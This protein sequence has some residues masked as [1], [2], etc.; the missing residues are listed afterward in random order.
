MRTYT[1][2]YDESDPRNLRYKG[3]RAQRRAGP[4]GRIQAVPRHEQEGR[5]ML[6]LGLVGSGLP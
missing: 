5:R 3:V 1:A 6:G 4:S 2:A